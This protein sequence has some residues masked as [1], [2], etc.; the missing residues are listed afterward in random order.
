MWTKIDSKILPTPP[1]AFLIGEWK[2]IRTSTKTCRKRFVFLVPP[3]ANQNLHMSKET[4]TETNVN[5]YYDWVTR[6][7]AKENSSTTRSDLTVAPVDWVFYATTPCTGNLSGT[8]WATK[9]RVADMIEPRSERS[10]Y[11]PLAA[12]LGADWNVE[13]RLRA[14]AVASVAAGHTV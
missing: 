9:L 6:P 1:T 12:P 8:R 13:T 3:K 4:K 5:Y 11:G 7:P 14:S 10:V 2:L